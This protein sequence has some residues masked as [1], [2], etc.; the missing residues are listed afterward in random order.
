MD[1]LWKS[2][3]AKFLSYSYR[4]TVPSVQIAGELVT[5]LLNTNF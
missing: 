2:L 3:Y 4:K 1:F 5:E